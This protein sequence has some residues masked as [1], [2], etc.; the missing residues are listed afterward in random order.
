MIPKHTFALLRAIY[1]ADKHGDGKFDDVDDFLNAVAKAPVK[2][3]PE[4]LKQVYEFS[5]G[6]IIPGLIQ[7][8]FHHKELSELEKVDQSLQTIK[9]QL[10]YLYQKDSEYKALF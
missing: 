6:F 8:L 7:D 3:D 2:L 9:S 5:E 10:L 4:V 1:G